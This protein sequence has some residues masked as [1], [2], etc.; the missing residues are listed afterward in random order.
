MAREPI[1][2]REKLGAAWREFNAR[3][4]AEKMAR[5]REACRRWKTRKAEVPRK[6]RKVKAAP[7]A[8]TQATVRDV[9]DMDR[10]FRERI[11]E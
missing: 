3:L 7:S 11:A 10:A 2:G 1:A 8:L 6:A 5:H 4:R 9:L